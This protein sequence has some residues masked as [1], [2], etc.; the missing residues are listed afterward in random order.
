MRNIST[1]YEFHIFNSCY[2]TSPYGTDTRQ[3]DKV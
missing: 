3:P 2:A 1:I